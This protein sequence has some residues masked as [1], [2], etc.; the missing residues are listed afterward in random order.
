MTT[1]I[2]DRTSLIQAQ[3]AQEAQGQSLRIV[4]IIGPSH[5]LPHYRLLDEQTLPFV[6]VTETSS[7]G[8]VPELN[9]QNDLNVSVFLMDG[10]ELVGA[11]QN[12]IL[13]TD[14][15]IPAKIML[16]IPVSCVEAGRWAYSSP[17][18]S[19][20]KTASHRVRSGKQA[21][22]HESLKEGRKHDANQGEVWREVSASLSAAAVPS[23]TSSLHDAYDAR[24]SELEHFRTSLRMPPEAVGV[25]VFRG[26]DFQGMDL[27]DR[28]ATLK[29]FWDSLLDSYAIDCIGEAVDP[30]A[31]A[32][33]TVSQKIKAVFEQAALG[34]WDAFESPGEGQEWRMED[35]AYTGSALVWQDQV[36]VHL[37]VFP[38]QA[39]QNT[40]QQ[41]AHRRPRIQRQWM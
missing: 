35:P 12:R 4:P 23:P 40:Q 34:R 27:F 37:Q 28:H 31:R 1:A 8:S 19:P 10:Q 15:L 21:R 33:Q 6:Q 9:V 41:A 29:Y 20:G 11:K 22:V 30:A 7:A 16:A 3:E 17:T 32:N 24:K 14:V 2:A 38:K 13:N 36:V 26:D 18:F 25:A 39:M 5:E